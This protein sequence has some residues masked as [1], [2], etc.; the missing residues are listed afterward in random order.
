MNHNNNS[1]NNSG[2]QQHL[3]HQQQTTNTTAVFNNS[4]TMMEATPADRNSAARSTTT[5]AADGDENQSAGNRV[6]GIETRDEWTPSPSSQPAVVGG[7]SSISSKHQYRSHDDVEDSLMASRSEL[8]RRREKQRRLDVRIAFE[9]LS[10]IMSLVDPDGGSNQRQ[11]GEGNNNNKKRKKRNSD[12]DNANRVEMIYRA[13]K[14]MRRLYYENEASKK[15][16]AHMNLGGVGGRGSAAQS[17]PSAAAL[18]PLAAAAA[19]NGGA[20]SLFNAGNVGGQQRGMQLS[21]N[22]DPERVLVMVPTL[23]LVDSPKPVARA[24]YP[25]YYQ[26]QMNQGVLP[27]YALSPASQ[28]HQ[29]LNPLA[30]PS[31]AGVHRATAN[32]DSAT[33]ALLRGNGRGRAALDASGIESPQGIWWDVSPSTTS[34]P[35]FGSSASRL[36]P[37]LPHAPQLSAAAGSF[38]MPPTAAGALGAGPMLDPRFSQRRHPA[39]A[40]AAALQQQRAAASQANFADVFHPFARRTT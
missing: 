16:L 15:L 26:Q 27:D 38:P 11:N 18:P 6:N 24:K 8:K 4:V 40:A 17:P 34:S 9:E 20:A 33:A 14:I 31:M 21:P 39:A 12:Q 30:R 19:G 22:E 13:T 7:D 3:Q 28:F 37:T 32:A 25:S 1:S 10:T 36:E 2:H 23:A 29:H 5:A 35:S